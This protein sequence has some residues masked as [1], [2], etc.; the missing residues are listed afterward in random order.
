MGD[1]NWDFD[2]YWTTNHTLPDGVS[3]H[4]KPQVNGADAQCGPVTC[5]NP[6]SRYDVYRHEI[7]AAAWDP[8]FITNLS[9]R[10]ATPPPANGETGAPS[11]SASATNDTPDRRIFY[12]A[13]VNCK[14]SLPPSLPLSGG[15]NTGVP[16]AAFGKFFITEP[17]TGSQDEIHAELLE[18]VTPGNTNGVNFDQVQLYR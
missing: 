7:L 1:G 15:H 5:T 17:V 11:C 12:A 16:V 10:G 9:G 4:S 3:V 2:R 8:T 6:I 13:I 18:L 14:A